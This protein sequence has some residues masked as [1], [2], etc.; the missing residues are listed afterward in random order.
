MSVAWKGTVDTNGEDVRLLPLEVGEIVNVTNFYESY[1]E[2][3]G[4]WYGETQRGEGAF[5]SICVRILE[6]DVTL[7]LEPREQRSAPI[8]PIDCW[9]QILPDMERQ[10]VTAAS[11]VCKSWNKVGSTIT[12]K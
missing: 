6:Q 2:Y 9:R 1:P 3:S 10:D 12:S 5:P 8:L 11:L 4:W 7:P